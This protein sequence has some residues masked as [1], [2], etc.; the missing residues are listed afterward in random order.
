MPFTQ[1]YTDER[2]YLLIIGDGV[3]QTDEDFYRWCMTAIDKGIEFGRSR[4]LFDNRTLSVDLAQYDI[5][6][7]AD[8]LAQKDIQRMG[9]RFAVLSCRKTPEGSN[10]VE[11]AF[12]NRS[13]EYKRFDSK[14]EA[15]E[16]LL[17]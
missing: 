11:T 5:V 15:L 9:L 14:E 2:E 7:V 13:A 1:I 16:W 8:Q 10:R 12:V 3:L 4:F 6:T 17:A